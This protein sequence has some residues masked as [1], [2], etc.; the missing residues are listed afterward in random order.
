MV[1]TAVGEGRTAFYNRVEILLIEHRFT[2][3]SLTEGQISQVTLAAVIAYR[4]SCIISR[5]I[6][7]LLFIGLIQKHAFNSNNAKALY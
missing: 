6:V 7:P 3:H 4:G 1:G 5:N 2:T